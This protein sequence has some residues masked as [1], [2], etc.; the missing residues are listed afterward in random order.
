MLFSFDWSSRR[1][2]KKNNNNKNREKPNIFIH[3][4]TVKR[5]KTGERRRKFIYCVHSYRFDY[6]REKHS[7]YN[8]SIGQKSERRRCRARKADIY[9]Y[10]MMENA[11]EQWEKIQ[12]ALAIRLWNWLIRIKKTHSVRLKRHWSKSQSH[13]QESKNPVECGEKY[14]MI[15][16]LAHQKMLLDHRTLRVV[17][18]YCRTD[19]I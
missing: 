6:I 11:C 17:V 18:D 10:R 15:S 5:R 4:F 9:M 7:F 3:A 13:V 1:T 19:V 14:K 16:F 8:W 12:L 2:K